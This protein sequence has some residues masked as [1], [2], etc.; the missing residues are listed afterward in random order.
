VL[1][2]FVW[3]ANHFAR[4]TGSLPSPEWVVSATH[5]LHRLLSASG[6]PLPFAAN[7]AVDLF[8]PR[9]R[10]DRPTASGQVLIGCGLYDMGAGPQQTMVSIDMPFEPYD[11]AQGIKYPGGGTSGRGINVP[12]AQTMARRRSLPDPALT[13][14]A[15]SWLGDNPEQVEWEM[16][17]WLWTEEEALARSYEHSYSIH[18]AKSLA[19]TYGE[20]RKFETS[21]MRPRDWLQVLSELGLVAANYRILA[22]DEPSAGPFATCEF[23]LEPTGR[24]LQL[25]VTLPGGDRTRRFMQVKYDDGEYADFDNFIYPQSQPEAAALQYEHFVAFAIPIPDPPVLPEATP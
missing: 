25:I 19:R 2:D 23:A 15:R 6:T 10:S 9:A 17:D 12:N 8:K 21:P 20:W 4:E 1:D 7:D 5:P 22:S 16:Q 24:Y 14:L 3:Y 11:S 18:A 13:G